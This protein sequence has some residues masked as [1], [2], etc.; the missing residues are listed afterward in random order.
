MKETLEYFI[1]NGGTTRAEGT[2]QSYATKCGHLFRRL[3]SID[4]NDPKIID[5]L[6]QYISDRLDEGASQSTVAKEMVTLRQALKVAHKRRRLVHNPAAIVPS[7]S[8]KYVPRRRYLVPEELTALLDGLAPERR[9]WMLLAVYTGGRL[10]EVERLT[11]DQVDLFEKWILLPGTKTEKS[12]RRVPIPEPLVAMLEEVKVKQGAVVVPWQ[13]VRRDLTAACKTLDIPNVTPND[14][15]RTYASWLKQ[16]GVDSKVV[17]DLLGHT[18][19]RMVDL[20]YGHLDDATFISAT[21]LL[22]APPSS[23]AGSKWVADRGQKR[24]QMGLVRTGST[25]E[26]AAETMP[27]DRIELPTRGFSIP[28]STN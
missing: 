16:R 24:R 22:P 15:R 1:E 26:K 12:R 27:R 25:I 28:C 13:N 14:L 18:S 19:T 20:V 8:A 21:E 2:M 10:S 5:H 3:G 11:W 17:A 7:L 23:E 6:Q 9:L 4:V